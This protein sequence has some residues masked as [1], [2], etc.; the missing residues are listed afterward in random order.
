M[1]KPY[2]QMTAAERLADR[3][4]KNRELDRRVQ[5]AKSA[6]S[7]PAEVRDKRKAAADALEEF[8]RIKREHGIDAASDFVRNKS[9]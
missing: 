8:Q 2:I 7:A 1:S 6:A 5:E 4:A 9:K 3:M